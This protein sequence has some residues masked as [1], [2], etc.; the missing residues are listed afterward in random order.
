LLGLRRW[1]Y[2]GATPSAS[3]AWRELGCACSLSVWCCFLFV[4]RWNSQ[5]AQSLVGA[6]PWEIVLGVCCRSSPRVNEHRTMRKK[7]LSASAIRLPESCLPTAKSFTHWR[8]TTHHFPILSHV[9]DNKQT[10]KHQEMQSRSFSNTRSNPTLAHSPSKA[11]QDA[12]SIGQAHF[13]LG[14]LFPPAQTGGK[15]SPP[16]SSPLHH[17]SA[18][19]PRPAPSWLQSNRGPPSSQSHATPFSS[20]IP[21]SS[22]VHAVAECGAALLP[23]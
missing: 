9:A 15:P 1:R 11:L 18:S 12:K 7:Q 19:S 6:A 20:A 5:I 21:H 22:S 4:D 16:F 23:K 3:H 17:P 2:A 13:R 8:E 10:Y 14:L